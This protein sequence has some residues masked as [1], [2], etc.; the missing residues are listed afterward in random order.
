[1]NID[2]FERISR[3]TIC[4]AC[5][6]AAVLTGC[7]T[8]PVQYLPDAEQ[9][10]EGQGG[11]APPAGSA[12]LEFTTN[13]AAIAVFQQRVGEQLCE[14]E[15]QNVVASVRRREVP[16][17]GIKN[18]HGLANF[19][20]LGALDR[21]E[22]LPR[23]KIAHYPADQPIAFAA[24]SHITDASC[25]PM[26]LRF[27]PQ[28]A[29]RY[30]LSMDLQG[31]SCRLGIQELDESAQARPVKHSRWRCHKSL[32]GIGKPTLDGPDEIN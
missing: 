10:I 4:M 1:M 13:S 6:A 8:P 26:F 21:I 12:T 5:A 31:Q 7:A 30:S 9:V 29:K 3:L 24:S 27:T 18:F 15:S 2:T 23:T 19:M 28:A 20:S 11:A 32:L 22:K 25:G 17:F 14:P 16:S